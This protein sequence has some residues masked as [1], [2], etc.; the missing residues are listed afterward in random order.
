MAPEAYKEFMERDSMGPQ[1]D[2]WTPGVRTLGID[3]SQNFRN[4]RCR[5]KRIKGLSLSLPLFV[6]I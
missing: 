4:S 6:L 3:R 5:N 1:A 2:F